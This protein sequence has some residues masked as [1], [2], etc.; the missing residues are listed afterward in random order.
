MIN[1]NRNEIDREPAAALDLRVHVKSDVGHC[2]MLD[3]PPPP[4]I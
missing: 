1:A 4:S 3:D 2:C